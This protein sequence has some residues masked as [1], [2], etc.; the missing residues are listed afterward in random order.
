MVVEQSDVEKRA[1]DT[2][3]DVAL[4]IIFLGTDVNDTIADLIIAQMLFLGSGRSRKD[5]QLYIN[6]PADPSP[7]AWVF[8][9]P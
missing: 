4:T 3:L 9:T 7:Q 2:I 1:F 5:I 6:S 8:M